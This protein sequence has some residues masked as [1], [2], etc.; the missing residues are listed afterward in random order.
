MRLFGYA[1]FGLGLG[2]LPLAGAALVLDLG[3]LKPLYERV[4]SRYLQR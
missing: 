4:A 3:A 2:L 1:I